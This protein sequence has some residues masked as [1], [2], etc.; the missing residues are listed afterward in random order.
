[1]TTQPMARRTLLRTGL[2]GTALGAAALT[3]PGVARAGTASGAPESVQVAEIYQL[4]AAFGRSALSRATA[5]PGPGRGGP[6]RRQAA[7]DVG[8]IS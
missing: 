3:I 6:C 8:P 4:Q 7:Q 1:M 5:V 2:T